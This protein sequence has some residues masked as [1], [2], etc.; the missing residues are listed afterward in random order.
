MKRFNYLARTCIVSYV[1]QTIHIKGVSGIQHVLFIFND[2]YFLKF[3]S[4][5]LWCPACVYVK[6]PALFSLLPNF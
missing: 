5:P 3:L 1:A 6:L 2:S 4:V